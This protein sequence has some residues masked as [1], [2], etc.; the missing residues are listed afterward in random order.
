M[1]RGGIRDVIREMLDVEQQAQQIV[2]DAEKQ[3]QNLLV[4]A[5]DEAERRVEEARHHAVEQSHRALL[6]ATEGAQRRRAEEIRAQME[7]DAPVVEA[8]RGNSSKAIEIVVHE[9]APG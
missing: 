3:A 8:A 1:D 4:Q 9:V 7:Q 6:A 2:G 5:R